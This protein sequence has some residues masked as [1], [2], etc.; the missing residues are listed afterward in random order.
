MN[1][2]EFSQLKEPIALVVDD[3]PLILMD[4][5]QMVADEGY[6]IVEAKTAQQAFE[7]LEHH[8]SL[9][10]LFT[11]VQTPGNINGFELAR[12]VAEKWPH[13]AIVITSGAARPKTGDI[14][15]G[16]TFLGKPLSEQVI[17]DVIKAHGHLD[18]GID[19][20]AV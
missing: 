7:F 4:T 10:L 9:Q 20:E 8:S 11:D 3:E 17:H 5:A 12:R 18:H 16:A 15:E 13:I 6:S 14:P 19:Q 2:Q 1:A